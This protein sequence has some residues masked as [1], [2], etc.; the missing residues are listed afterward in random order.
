[1]PSLKALTDYLN[2]LVTEVLLRLNKPVVWITPAGLKISLSTLKK[3]LT[4]SKLIQSSNPVTI[5]F[6]NC[7]FK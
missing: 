3:V 5:I 7:F 2:D 1:M 4:S 6:T